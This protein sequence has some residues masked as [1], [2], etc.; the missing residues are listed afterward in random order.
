LSG[1]PQ[2]S[3]ATKTKQHLKTKFESTSGS[4]PFSFAKGALSGLAGKRGN[5]ESY[6]GSDW[7]DSNDEG[8][9]HSFNKVHKDRV[10]IAKNNL[11][12]NIF[13]NL[14]LF[15]CLGLVFS[16]DWYCYYDD[17]TTTVTYFLLFNYCQ[18]YR[19]PLTS[20]YVLKYYQQR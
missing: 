2:S 5:K 14:F 4:G 9:C 12:L 15:A 13:L 6:G 17:D 10:F 20:Q 7:S 11:K 3:K 16:L 1:F 18:L 19:T 8:S